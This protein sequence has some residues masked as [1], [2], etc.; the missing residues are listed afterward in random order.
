[1]T[2]KFKIIA[3][4]IVMI[5]L[6]AVMAISG[7]NGLKTASGNFSEYHYLT[8]FTAA[9]NDLLDARNAFLG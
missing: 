3:G 8:T 6:A 5:V 4:F 1:M 7:V 2:T 9:I